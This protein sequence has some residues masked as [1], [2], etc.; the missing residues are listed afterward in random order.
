[1]FFNNSPMENLA[2]FA[3]VFVSG[4]LV[5]AGL[6]KYIDTVR[7]NASGANRTN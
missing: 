5:A 4:V 2:A 3:I 1:M 6:G 7:R